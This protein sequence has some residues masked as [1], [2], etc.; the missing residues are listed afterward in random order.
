MLS[1]FYDSHMKI[2]MWSNCRRHVFYSLLSICLETQSSAVSVLSQPLAPATVTSTDSTSS[3]I[4]I[5]PSTSIS[6][7]QRP[8]NTSSS[9]PAV[10]VTSHSPLSNV[11]NA[12]S[13]SPSSTPTT[14]TTTATNEDTA[15]QLPRSLINE[16]KPFPLNLQFKK[17]S[18]HL[19]PSSSTS[20]SSSS[21]KTLLENSNLAETNHSAV[22]DPV[23]FTEQ[24]RSLIASNPVVTDFSI[25]SSE[26][27]SSV[28]NSASRASSANAN[29]TA[30]NYVD[31][32]HFAHFGGSPAPPSYHEV[33]VK[34]SPAGNNFM[35]NLNLNGAGLSYG[36]PS[37]T[38]EWSSAPPSATANTYSLQAAVPTPV[39]MSS[40]SSSSSSGIK[41]EPQDYPAAA[42]NGQSMHLPK[43]RSYAN[44][45]S[46][47]PVHERPFSCPVENCPR[48]FSR[49]DE[50]TR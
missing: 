10:V 32:S 5:E 22:G 40:S 7:D 37:V 29:E 47:T 50:L 3:A 18:S 49:S 42:G 15:M 6:S 34:S 25:N 16:N 11:V 17:P 21:G 39:S 35:P 23:N 38:N 19:P 45:P 36:K 4:D 30:M 28:S 44:R 14:T 9:I 41:D 26:G 13:T 8:S 43:Q 46:K 20:S 1:F 48:R 24:I 2:T 27:P 12:A 33:L 31:Q